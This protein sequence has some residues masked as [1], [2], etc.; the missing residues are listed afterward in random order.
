[1]RAIRKLFA[2]YFAAIAVFFILTSLWSFFTR[3]MSVTSCVSTC[4][5][6]L[7]SLIWLMAGWAIVMEK[8]LASAW[9]VVASLLI[10]AVPLILSVARHRPLTNARVAILVTGAFCLNC[11]R[12]ARPRK[13][14]G[15]EEFGVAAN[16]PI[17][18]H[19]DT[20]AKKL[21][22]SPLP[23]TRSQQGKATVIFA[24]RMGGELE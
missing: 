5:L 20:E 23:T 13:R 8:P 24:L 6:L 11:L 7:L 2:G 19:L 1:M 9:G 21:P 10:I 16:C 22:M 17:T 15:I 14:I 4:A 3:A 12:V 18:A